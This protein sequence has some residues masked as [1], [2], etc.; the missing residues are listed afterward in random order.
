M[1][2]APL[3]PCAAG[4]M[5]AKACASG[6]TVLDLWKLADQTN[7]QLYTVKRTVGTNPGIIGVRFIFAQRHSQRR[8][9]CPSIQLHG[10]CLLPSPQANVTIV[11]VG[12]TSEGCAAHLSVGTAT[13]GQCQNSA[14]GL[15]SAAS[16]GAQSWLLE[17]VPGQP[18]YVYISNEVRCGVRVSVNLIVC[19]PTPAP[20]MLAGAARSGVRH[21][22][23]GR[24]HK[25]QRHRDGALCDRQPQRHPHVAAHSCVSRCVIN[26]LP[27]RRRRRV[28]CSNMKQPHNPLISNLFVP[29]L[30]HS[31]LASRSQ[32]PC[33]LIVSA[34]IS[35]S[36]PISLA[37]GIHSILAG[38]NSANAA[39][40]CCCLT[41]VM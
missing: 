38:C 33:S 12:R 22:L 3:G 29:N 10:E 13:V 2:A 8:V 7:R 41:V 37:H 25:L 20:L 23:P 19:L 14:S 36:I 40:D 5:S 30:A 16:P 17:N 26:P 31:P 11:D 1:S 6:K 39:S 24:Q 32:Q 15:G 35:T 27:M 34:S 18:G 4:Y 9:H 28:R 21:A